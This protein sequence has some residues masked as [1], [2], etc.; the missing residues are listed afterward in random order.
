[1]TPHRTTG[2]PGWR[3]LRQHRIARQRKEAITHRQAKQEQIEDAPAPKRAAPT[4]RLARLGALPE[5]NSNRWTGVIIWLVGAY[6]TSQLLLQMGVADPY[7]SLFGFALQWALTKAEGPLWQGKGYPRMALFATFIDGGVNAGGVWPFMKN[8][9]QTDF[10][11]M[12]S[13]IAG[14]PNLEPSLITIIACSVAIG[15]ATAAAAE[16][17][18]NL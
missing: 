13:E 1:M 10:W 17:F 4:S 5:M 8:L 3:E 15:L 11:R 7:S 2:A 16:Y 9:G 12:I 6:L 18:W 14:Q